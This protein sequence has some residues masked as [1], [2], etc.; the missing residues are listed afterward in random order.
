MDVKLFVCIF[1]DARLLPHFLRHYDRFGITEFHIAAAPHL[2]E[3]V[4]TVSAGYKVVQYNEFDVAESVTGG[5]SAVAAMRERA[6]EADEWVVIV[7]L[8]EFV[9]FDVPVPQTIASMEAEGANVARGINY[10]RFAADGRPR[11]FDDSSDLSTLFPVRA[12]FVRNVMGGTDVKGVLVRGHLA[13]RKGVGHHVFENEVLYSKVF[14]ISHYKWT[15]PSL[16]RMRQAYEM[17]KAAGRDWADEYQVVLDHYAT[18]G[19]FAWE[20]FGGELAEP[21]R[22]LAE[23]ERTAAELTAELQAIKQRRV[24]RLADRILSA[25]SWRRRAY[26]RL[27]KRKNKR[28]A[29]SPG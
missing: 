5:V 10:D 23:V 27:T 15:D 26:E 19:R 7:D 22:R 28:P 1:D 16:K 20:T 13:S 24:V 4:S 8:D 6:Q 11:P 2:A 25:D 29:Q 9:E 14:E 21:A 12:R 18:H 17:S 3:Y